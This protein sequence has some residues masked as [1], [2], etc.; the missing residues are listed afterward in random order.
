MVYIY[1]PPQGENTI[2]PE[3]AT[4]SSTDVAF[5]SITS[6]MRA[7]I[8]E[9]RRDLQLLKTPTKLPEK[10]SCY[11]MYSFFDDD[12]HARVLGM[13]SPT[14]RVLDTAG[15][16]PIFF[17]GQLRGD[18]DSPPPFRW[19]M[20]VPFIL[21]PEFMRDM[22][23]GIE[24]DEQLIIRA[25][26]QRKDLNIVDETEG[27][28]DDDEF[29]LLTEE[30]VRKILKKPLPNW[31]FELSDLD[32]IRG[33]LINIPSLVH[34]IGHS[35]NATGLAVV[36]RLNYSVILNSSRLLQDAAAKL[37]SG[38]HLSQTLVVDVHV[39]ANSQNG[40]ELKSFELESKNI[41]P[42]PTGQAQESQALI[43]NARLIQAFTDIEA[44]IADIENDNL[45]T[46][47]RNMGD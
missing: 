29:K 20:R 21:L 25:Q 30:A 28:E 40:Q 41:A 22:T 15:I 26:S 13:Q 36:E 8:K 31:L 33:N 45:E 14:E 7:Q 1:T 38:K 24:K 4:I 16:Y 42:I 32:K 18:L 47:E 27:K 44:I 19:V 43:E 12:A 46:E 37:L 35:I 10:S 17:S 5:R 23:S 2:F 6:Q 39:F 34:L 3:Q 11:M 9:R